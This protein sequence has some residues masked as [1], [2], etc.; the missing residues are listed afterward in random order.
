MLGNEKESNLTLIADGI[1][2]IYSDKTT[3]KMKQGVL[4]MYPVRAAPLSFGLDF[5]IGSFTMDVHL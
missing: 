1:G 2:Q 3:K 5:A 4:L